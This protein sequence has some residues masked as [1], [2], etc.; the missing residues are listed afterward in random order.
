M[1]R[2]IIRSSQEQAVAAIPGEFGGDNMSVVGFLDGRAAYIQ[3]SPDS[4]IGPGY[5]FGI[6]W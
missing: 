4:L 6:T 2:L 1:R 5:T 3:V